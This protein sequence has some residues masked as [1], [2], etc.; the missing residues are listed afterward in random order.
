MSRKKKGEPEGTENEE[1]ESD[2]FEKEEFESEYPK[3]DKKPSSVR[4]YPSGEPL[5]KSE[6]GQLTEIEEAAPYDLSAEA[7]TKVRDYKHLKL[8][9]NKGKSEKDYE[10]TIEGQSH[11]FCNVLVKHLLATEGVNIAA[12]KITSLTPPKVYI[13]LENGNYKI[14]DVVR[15]S[16]ESLREEVL[17]VQKL[18]NSLM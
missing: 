14:K 18:F 9:L 11:G 15:K 16:I 13:R 5:D 2:E 3:I 6:E 1:F 4:E 17:E 8:S 7:E 10:L 12:Y